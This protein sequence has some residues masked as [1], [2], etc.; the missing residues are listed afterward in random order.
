MMLEEHVVFVSSTANA[1]EHVAL[2][3]IVDIRAKS[4]NNLKIVSN[5]LLPSLTQ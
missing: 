1:A 2:H 4:V 5:V 3:E